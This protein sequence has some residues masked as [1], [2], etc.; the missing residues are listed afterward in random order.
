MDVDKDDRPLEPVLISRCGELEKRKKKPAAQPQDAAPSQSCD[1]GR[2][3]RS[4]S[5]DVEMENSPE[6]AGDPSVGDIVTTSTMKAS[7]DDRDRD[8]VHDRLRVHCPTT[9]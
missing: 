5:S 1:R 2:R 3:R 4:N 8:Q 9:R 6:H 7:E